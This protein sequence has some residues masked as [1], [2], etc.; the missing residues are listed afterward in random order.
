MEL[1]RIYDQPDNA[2]RIKKLGIGDS[3]SA[4]AFRGPAVAEK[5]SKLLSSR[6]VTAACLAVAGKRRD[7]DTLKETCEFIERTFTSA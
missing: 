7:D 3:L 4:R 6:E 2:S 5:L 1:A